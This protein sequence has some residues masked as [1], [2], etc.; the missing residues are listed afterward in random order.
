MRLLPKEVYSLIYRRSSWGSAALPPCSIQM[1]SWERPERC[2]RIFGELCPMFVNYDDTQRQNCSKKCSC[3]STAKL[4]SFPST[5]TDLFTVFFQLS[6]FQRAVT[7]GV[8]FPYFCLYNRAL[9]ALLFYFLSL[10]FHD[11]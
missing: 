4:L 1:S 11:I 3:F 7:F 5:F 2:R 8:F 6:C 9:M 10:S